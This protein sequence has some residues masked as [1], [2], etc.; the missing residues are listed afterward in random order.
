MIV[1]TSGEGSRVFPEIRIRFRSSNP[2]AVSPRLQSALLLT[3]FA[4]IGVLAFLG[5]NWIQYGHRVAEKT[6]AAARLRNTNDD[7][8]KQLSGLRRELADAWQERGH[9]QQETAAL[10]EQTQMLRGQLSAADAKLQSLAL[11]DDGF[12]ELT[13]DIQKLGA[14]PVAGTGPIAQPEPSAQPDL[15]AQPAAKLPSPTTI[16]TASEETR[17]ALQ[18]EQARNAALTAQLQQ[19]QSDRTA[20]VSQLAQYK[21][22]LEQTARELAQFGALRDKVTIKRGRLRLQIND[23]WR[24]L[25]LMRLPLPGPGI[26]AAGPTA[27]RGDVASTTS[28]AA[29][30]GAKSLDTATVAAVENVLR[31]AG[32][33]LGRIVGRIMSQGS[34]AAAEGGPFVPPPDA[35]AAKSDDASAEKLAAIEALSKTLPIAA[36]LTHYELGSRFGPRIDPFNHRAAFHT[37]IDMDAPYSSPVYATAP[38]TVIY[39]GWLGDYGQAIEIDHGYGIVTLYG[40]LRRCLVAVGQ[41][42]SAQTEIGLLGS[43][44]R[45]TGPHVHYEV[46]VDGQPQDPQ[47]FL[48]LAHLLPATTDRQ[49]T[50]AVGGPAGNSR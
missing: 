9:A 36:P 14:G 8:R 23:I 15:T 16:A 34:P 20:E 48:S 39:A 35:S 32:V 46:R 45:S 38:G 44:G 43:T 27:Q 50:P 49:V 6:A 1:E 25:S 26:A 24:R 41:T 13:G 40:H 31:S 28:D 29:G 12:A 4:G 18:Q 37:G 19:I 42:V 3:V 2:V 22:S 5:V 21:A 47:K 33:N 7:L 17:Q 30:S 11:V 10:S